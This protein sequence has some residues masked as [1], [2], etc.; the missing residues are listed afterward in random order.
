MNILIPLQFERYLARAIAHRPSEPHNYR[1]SQSTWGLKQQ[2]SQHLLQVCWLSASQKPSFS[3]SPY[4]LISLC[5]V[6]FHSAMFLRSVPCRDQA[7]SSRAWAPRALCGQ[8]M[9]S[10][11]W[12][13]PYAM[14]FPTSSACLLWCAQLC[15]QLAPSTLAVMHVNCMHPLI[16]HIVESLH[17]QATKVELEDW[18]ACAGLSSAR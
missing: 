9:M 5:C 17:M 13:M 1:L 12:S 7:G 8:T 14:F 2:P 3:N 15:A 10:G 16:Y 11:L 4:C 18:I 6:L